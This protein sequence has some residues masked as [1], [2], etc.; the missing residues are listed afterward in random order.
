[1]VSGSFNYPNRGTFHRSIALLIHYR[2]PS[3]L[4]PLMF[5]NDEKWTPVFDVHNMRKERL[6]VKDNC[7]CAGRTFLVLPELVR[8]MTASEDRDKWPLV[9]C[10]EWLRLDTCIDGEKFG[11][12]THCIKIYNEVEEERW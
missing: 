1:M 12:S 2:L 10:G 6:T 3:S 9:S 5:I 7:G 8:G 4:Y 11:P